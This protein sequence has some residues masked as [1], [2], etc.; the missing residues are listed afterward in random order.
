[1]YKNTYIR[2]TRKYIIFLQLLLIFLFYE[3]YN[4]VIYINLIFLQVFFI[5]LLY[6]IY[7]LK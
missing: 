1:M 7:Y 3:I 5:I 6:F 4:L 2:I